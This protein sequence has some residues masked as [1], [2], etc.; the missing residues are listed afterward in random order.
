MTEAFKDLSGFRHI[1]DDFVI[2]D[3]NVSDHESHVNQ[4][5]QCCADFNISLNTEKCQFFQ[6][7]V[8]FA[9]FQLSAEGYQVDSSI[10]AAITNYLTPTNCTEL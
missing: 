10:T 7:Q 1:V 2:C 5:L 3:S 8:T 6:H 4:F 9:G